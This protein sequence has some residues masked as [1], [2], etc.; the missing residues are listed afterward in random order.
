MSFSRLVLILTIIGSGVLARATNIQDLC[1]AK[2]LNT[3]QIADIKAAV[4]QSLAAED[5]AYQS[6][7]SIIL[8]YSAPKDKPDIA[9]LIQRLQ[10]AIANTRNAPQLFQRINEVIAQSIPISTEKIPDIQSKI[11]LLTLCHLRSGREALS[12]A[13]PPAT[14][15]APTTATQANQNTDAPSTP[16]SAGGG[17]LPIILLGTSL[18]A[19][20][21]SLYAIARIRKFTELLH[22]KQT[23]ALSE[24][25]MNAWLD[26][27]TTI[28][29]T[30]LIAL[31][32][33]LRQQ[34][35]DPPTT[36]TTNTTPTQQPTNNTEDKVVATE[37]P[38]PVQTIKYATMPME[39]AF[40]VRKMQDAFEVGKT[41]YKIVLSTD[42][43]SATYTLVDSKE[44]R[45]MAF[46]V[47]DSY[48]VPGF[49]L[50]GKGRLH[51]DSEIQITAG[52]LVKE[53]DNRY[54]ITKR[55][56]IEWW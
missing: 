11:A 14:T 54:K 3:L 20:L 49:D 43:L 35:L 31:K 26:K 55:A 37:P 33:Q 38:P 30:E 12:V 9:P 15:L 5:S 39:G 27:K 13:A 56:A 53:G 47:P 1:A 24:Q 51:T 10:E 46:N 4:K 16:S 28:L 48:L 7:M 44:A 40:S 50:K 42:G 19:L 32:E 17:W 34:Q 6:V 41:F 8:D 52:E 21:C 36:Q 45:A 23:P 22:A 25:D 18:L 2:E 29:Q